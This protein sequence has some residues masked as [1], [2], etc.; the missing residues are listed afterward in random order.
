[1]IQKRFW[2]DSPSRIRARGKKARSSGCD[3]HLVDLDRHATL[4]TVDRYYEALARR[5]ELQ[6]QGR[7]VTIWAFNR[8]GINRALF[9]GNRHRGWRRVKEGAS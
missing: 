7:S 5:I 8:A 1:M 2:Y 4:E 9:E 6:R 3:Y